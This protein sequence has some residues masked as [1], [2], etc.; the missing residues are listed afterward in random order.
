M[1]EC[2]FTIDYEIYGNG[3]GSLRELVYEPARKLKDTFDGAGAKMVVFVEVAELEKIELLKTDPM[4]KEVKKQTRELH[5]QGHEIGLHLHPQWCNARY[6][7]GKWVLDYSEY[8]LC[9]LAKERIGQIADRSI[10]YLRNA[11]GAADFIPHSF[12]AGNW[13]FQPTGTAA[14][15]LAEYGIKVD[16][17]VFKGGLQHEHGLDYRRASRNGYF[18]RF[19]D[20]VNT[21]DPNGKLLEIPI[22]TQMVPLW[23]MATAKRIGLQQKGSSGARTPKQRLNRFRDMARFWLPLKLDFCRMSL[24]ELTRMVD[25]VIVEDRQDPSSFKPLIAIGHTKDL[26]DFET[27]DS[28]LAYLRRMGIAVSTMR[29]AYLRCGF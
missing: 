18:W 8:N 11:L 14:R 5:Q 23:K 1:I 22:F 19:G 6:E 7:E 24:K 4:I 21:P 25:A 29:D 28:F 26:S 15:V 27:V 12:R 2:I 9:T 3:L 10:A 13:L 17:S 20:D 16:S